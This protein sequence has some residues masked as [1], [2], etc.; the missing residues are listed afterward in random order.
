MSYVVRDD[1][2]RL[3]TLPTRIPQRPAMFAPRMVALPPPRGRRVM[4]NAD[5]GL[6]FSLRPPKW[7]R[8]AQPGKILKKIALPV[9]AV[10]AALL[11]PG[12]GGAIVGG[13]TAVA[14]A[15]GGIFGK[16][17][18]L[19]KPASRI[20]TSPIQTLN[21]ATQAV[22][23]VQQAATSMLSTAQ[24][25]LPGGS[26]SIPT[27]V[28]MSQPSPSMSSSLPEG[29]YGPPAPA[30][31]AGGAPAAAPAAAASLPPWA[32]PAGIAV[33]ALVMSRRR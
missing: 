15:G 32:I 8:K 11:I 1:Q 21:T 23:G 4:N 14:K 31:A 3:G 9:A 24:S 17:T 18:S 19:L 30:D 10:G 12:V 13:A 29:Y 25:V 33:L 26:P 20:V 5:Y 2:G 6:G 7:V 16:I 28:L 27:P 22:Q